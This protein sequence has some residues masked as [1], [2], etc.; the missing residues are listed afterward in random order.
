MF[1][2]VQISNMRTFKSEIQIEIINMYIDK[3][4]STM[5]GKLNTFRGSV[6]KHCDKQICVFI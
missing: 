5:Y 2:S 3:N 6:W 4:L 1:V